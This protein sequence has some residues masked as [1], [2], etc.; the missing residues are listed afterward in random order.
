MLNTTKQNIKDG[1]RLLG[2]F[3]GI[4]LFFTAIPELSILGIFVIVLGFVL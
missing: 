4:M 3:L 1:I 2:F